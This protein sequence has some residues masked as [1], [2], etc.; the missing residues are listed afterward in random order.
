ML[1]SSRRTQKKKSVLNSS[2]LFLKDF[3]AIKRQLV[4]KSRFNLGG[5]L[6][7]KDWRTVAKHLRLL[8]CSAD[9]ALKIFADGS[10]DRFR[11][12]KSEKK[13]EKKNPWQH[14]EMK[15]EE[16]TSIVRTRAIYRLALLKTARASSSV[17]RVTWHLTPENRAFSPR[18]LLLCVLQHVLRK[19]N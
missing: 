3:L 4:F 2:L 15:M 6:S 18:L 8:F 7:T 17:A 14:M 16:Q 10:E 11:G 9:S 13:K 5:C 12:F 19:Y 1:T